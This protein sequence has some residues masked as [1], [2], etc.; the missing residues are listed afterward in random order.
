[1][2][3][4]PINI[5]ATHG[6][7]TYPFVETELLSIPDIKILDSIEGKI[8]F[9]MSSGCLDL[10]TSLKT[11]E[12][13]FLSVL[14]HKVSKKLTST[15]VLSLAKESLLANRHL[16][17][18]YEFN[19]IISRAKAGD[20][21]HLQAIKRVCHEIKFRVNCKLTGEWK[22][23]KSAAKKL[24]E[25]LDELISSAVKS[26][27]RQFTLDSMEPDFEVVCHVTNSA[28]SIGVP[29]SKRPLSVRS[30]VQVVGLRSTICSMMLQACLPRKDFTFVLGKIKIS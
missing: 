10:L 21:Q 18:S 3:D 27:R 11:V 17:L 14:F 23:S 22:L 30:Y 26:V 4:T 16:F 9:Q 20:D 2:S 5:C 13:V 28:V 8:F 7:G 6:R 25:D 24:R 29:I 12:R 19:S 1:M 15:D